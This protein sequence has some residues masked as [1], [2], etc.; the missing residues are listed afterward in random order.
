[1]PAGSRLGGPGR[2]SK[3]PLR[4]QILLFSDIHGDRRALEALLDRPADLYVAAGDLCTWGRNLDDMGAILARRASSTWLLPGNH[5]SA[6][7]IERLCARHGMRN[8]H[9]QS[10]EAGGITIAGL[11]YSNPTPFHTPGEYSEQQFEAKLAPF[12]TLKPLVM[13][14]HCPPRNTALDQI[15]PG[16]HAGSEAIAGFL[17]DVQPAYFFCGHIHEAEGV[18]IRLGATIAVNL[19]KRGYL[20][21]TDSAAA[22]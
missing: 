22:G 11:G 1:M 15:R 4:M 21:D 19:G 7:D 2:R 18:Q 20:L 16:L 9:E 13:V 8:L 14:C 10:F 3:I 12:R 5:E 17:A 6:A